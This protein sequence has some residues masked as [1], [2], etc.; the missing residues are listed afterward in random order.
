MPKTGKVVA[1]F[2][3]KSA[4][5]ESEFRLQ[6]P[7]NKLIFKAS[8]SQVGKTFDVGTFSAGQKL[9]FALKTPDGNTYYTIHAWNKDACDHVIKV[10]TGTYKWELRWEDLYGLGDQDYNDVVAEIEIK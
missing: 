4:A 7:T 1:K 3:S 6:S 10:Q 9:I 5:F 2:K 8:D